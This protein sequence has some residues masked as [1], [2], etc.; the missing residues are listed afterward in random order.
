[1]ADLQFYYLKSIEY[2]A[3][4]YKSNWCWA[5]C[6][7]NMII[8]LEADSSIGNSQCNLASY[9]QLYKQDP[10]CEIKKYNHCCNLDNLPESHCNIGINPDHIE[11]IYGLGGFELLEMDDLNPL[12]EFN[13]IKKT[14][15]EKKAPIL[16]KIWINNGFHANLITGFGMIGDCQY[17]LISDPAITK[18]EI[19]RNIKL[20]SD[21]IDIRQAWIS[22]KKHKNP[23]IKDEEINE[24]YK[25]AEDYIKDLDK[26]NL[27]PELSDPSN[28]IG[29]KHPVVIDDFL[30]TKNKLLSNT[31][32]RSKLIQ[33]FRNQKI[34]NKCQSQIPKRP[35]LS[36]DILELSLSDIDN[37]TD[38]IIDLINKYDARIYL[39]EYALEL[40]V[41]LKKSIKKNN[42]DDDLFINNKFRDAATTDMIDDSID[43]ITKIIDLNTYQEIKDVVVTP[44]SFPNNYN[45]NT[46]PQSVVAFRLA[47]TVLPKTLF[48]SQNKNDFN[49]DDPNPELIY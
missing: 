20:L 12:Y 3:Q 37:P 9:Y 7:S 36:G 49:S 23:L 43:D 13:W 45:L 31:N 22:E 2:K 19:Y 15:I 24:R 17:V 27:D 38:D 46:E 41:S 6:L 18:G 16:L 35:N 26:T 4:P 39:K 33:D 48:F 32:Q 11:D 14:L 1:M 44:I 25:K 5:S 42:A 30:D 34:N 40:K 21:R 8:G 47:I 28:Y 29:F 10:N